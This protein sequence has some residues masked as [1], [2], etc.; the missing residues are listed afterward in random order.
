M[1]HKDT[2]M[3][4]NL[5]EKYAK[6][7]MQLACRNGVPYDDAEDVVMES[8]WA[9]YDSEHYGKLDEQETKYMIARIVKNKCIDYYRKNKNDTEMVVEDSEE[10]LLRVG[11][12]SA[13]EPENQ[14]IEKENYRRIR[15]AIENMKPIFR[16]TAIMYFL[17]ERTFSEI[18]KE[19]GVSEPV[20]RKRIQRAREHLRNELR[21]L[22]KSP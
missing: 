13:K 20:C 14:M 21:D 12:H 11:V 4:Q 7:Y 9:F 10:T 17:Q 3:L 2:N 8:F 19:L 22:W 1:P 18:S 15:S 6:L 16:D 5:V